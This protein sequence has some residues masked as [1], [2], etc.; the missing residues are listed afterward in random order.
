MSQNLSSRVAKVIAASAHGLLDKWE[1][2]NPVAMLEQTTRE[3]QQVTED[4]R[5]ELGVVVANR[6]LV[7]Q[8]HVRLNHEHTE[9]A[10][11]VGAAI[12]AGKDDLAK[13]ALARQMDIEAQLPVLESSL[14]RLA[15]EEKELS[16]Y[17]EALMGKQ[18]EMQRAVQEFAASRQQA[19]T[20]M[21]SRPVKT[22]HTQARVQAV[23]DAFDRTLLRQTGVQGLARGATLE[24]ATKLHELGE[25][26]RDNQINE[27]LAALKAAQ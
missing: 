14:V 3:L 7:Q 25:M 1:D 19:L 2:A 10:Q 9:L 5:C 22:L 21:D 6:H 8:Q 11:S 15:G 23:Q 4:V 26:V 17:V 20:A 13:A 16:A 27:R 24:Q 18:R 12:A